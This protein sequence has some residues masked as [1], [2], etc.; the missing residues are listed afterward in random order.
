MDKSKERPQKKH[1]R[2][3]ERY[4]NDDYSR[5]AGPDYS[6]E[7]FEIGEEDFSQS[8]HSTQGINVREEGTWTNPGVSGK[9]DEGETWVNE[10][11]YKEQTSFVGFGPHG[12]KRSDDRIYEDVCETL[13][14]HKEID[15][16]NIGVKVE[17]GVVYLTGKVNTRKMKKISELITEDLPGV[18]DVS[19]ELTVIKGDDN[20]KGP[21]KA[22]KKDLGIN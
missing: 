18:K 14:R 22:T 2:L 16:T 3:V 9:S 20:P 1:L 11:E 5:Y 15:A 17:E 4:D 19:N 6:D 10:K 21:D 7:T 8:P 13:M 12:Y